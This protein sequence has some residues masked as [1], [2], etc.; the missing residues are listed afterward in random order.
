MFDRF[1]TQLLYP[2]HKGRLLPLYNNHPPSHFIYYKFNLRF[3]AN[4]K[5]TTR[6]FRG[7]MKPAPDGGQITETFNPAQLDV[8]I[9]DVLTLVDISELITMTS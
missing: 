3:P 4:L 1:R 6:S 8:A 7:I 2:I 9:D 5:S